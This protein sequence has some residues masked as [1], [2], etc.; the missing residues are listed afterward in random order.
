MSESNSVTQTR[1]AEW[2]ASLD[3]A[4]ETRTSFGTSDRGHHYALEVSRLGGDAGSPAW[5]RPFH[6]ADQAERVAGIRSSVALGDQVPSARQDVLRRMAQDRQG[7]SP[8]AK[9]AQA[10]SNAASYRQ[11]AAN[12][13]TGS[14]RESLAGAARQQLAQARAINQVGKQ[15]AQPVTLVS[16]A[17]PASRPKPVPVV[18]ITQAM[19]DAA[20]GTSRAAPASASNAGQRQAQAARPSRARL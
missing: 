7:L 19:R 4:T 11:A 9:G 13:G 8:A 10:L 20:R 12:L 5:S 17:A 1:Q 16:A 2:Q 14:G 18:V 15:A 3:G 6:T